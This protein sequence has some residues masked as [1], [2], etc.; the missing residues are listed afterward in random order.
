[1]RGQISELYSWV[2]CFIDYFLLSERLPLIM[3]GV[4]MSEVGEFNNKKNLDDE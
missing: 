3:I 4:Y 2:Q 1:M